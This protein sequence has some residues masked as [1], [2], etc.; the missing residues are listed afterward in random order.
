MRLL[1]G[2]SLLLAC[3]PA[4]AP[5]TQLTDADRAALGDSLMTFFDSVS[6]IH[7]THPDSALLVRLHPATDTVQLAEGGKVE[8]FTG[9]SMVRRVLAMHVPVTRMDQRFTER[10]ATVV[11]RDNVVVSAKEDVS[12][13]DSAGPHEFHGTLSLALVRVAGRWVI[14]GYRG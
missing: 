13:T 12:W 1:L 8:R 7:N 14:R 10:S 9:D 5:Q 3:R 11:D 4:P 6:A 2:L